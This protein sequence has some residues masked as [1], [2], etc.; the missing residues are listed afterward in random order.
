MVLLF[1]GA[2]RHWLVHS[3]LPVRRRVPG[4][5]ARRPN[6][7]SYRGRCSLVRQRYSDDPKTLFFPLS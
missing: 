1:P 6:D 7:P 2:A 3:A 5:T 4:G